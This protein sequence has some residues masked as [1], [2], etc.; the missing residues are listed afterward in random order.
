MVS[1]RAIGLR[2]AGVAVIAEDISAMFARQSLASP[3]PGLLLTLTCISM[4]GGDT[5]E[6]SVTYARFV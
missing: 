5:N 4:S 1:P 3:R 2:V 6:G